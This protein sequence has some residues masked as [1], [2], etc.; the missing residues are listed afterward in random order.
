MTFSHLSVLSFFKAIMNP[1]MK[2]LVFWILLERIYLWTSDRR[3]VLLH[4]ILSKVVATL[5]ALLFQ[6]VFVLKSLLKQ[7]EQPNCAYMVSYT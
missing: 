6:A 1:N 7:F 2:F 5:T 3:G 4:E